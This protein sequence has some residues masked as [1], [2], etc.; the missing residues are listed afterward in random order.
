VRIE[1]AFAVGMSKCRQHPCGKDGQLLKVAAVERQ[2]PNLLLGDHVRERR[3]F[4]LEEKRSGGDE[5][6]VGQCAKF[7]L[8]IDAHATLRV[9]L[10]HVTD[11]SLESW[12]LHADPVASD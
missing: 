12:P 5:D 11:A 7:E 1:S 9:D 3:G 8:E 6:L 2:L 4:R 10:D